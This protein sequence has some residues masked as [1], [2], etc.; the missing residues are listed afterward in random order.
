MFDAS[1]YAASVV[2]GQH[3][4][5]TVHNTYYDDAQNNYPQLKMRC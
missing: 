2:L 3:I 4:E 1:A 5:K